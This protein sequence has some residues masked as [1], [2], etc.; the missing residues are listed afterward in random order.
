Q[1]QCRPAGAGRDAVLPGRAGMRAGRRALDRDPGCR[2]DL[3]RAGDA[4]SR[5]QA[6]AE[7]MIRLPAVLLALALAA[8]STE[9]AA[10]AALVS[11]EPRDGAVVETVPE[12][13]VL[14]F[15]EPVTP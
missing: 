5:H 15:N 9:V 11:S 4:R 6:A 8:F 10:H 1:P 14:T 7:A 2:Q 13:L 12:H 3:R